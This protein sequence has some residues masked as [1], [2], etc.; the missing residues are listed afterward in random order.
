MVNSWSLLDSELNGT[1]DKDYPI[2]DREMT[3]E[4][5][6][7]YESPDGGKTVTRRKPGDDYTKKEVIKGDYFDGGQ[8]FEQSYLSDN[9]D[10]AAHHFNLNNEVQVNLQE[11]ESMT[12]HYLSLIH[13]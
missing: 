11:T 9:D 12:A 7:V 2:K 3:E 4:Q 10:Q 5:P 1:M 8:P 6:W 13:I